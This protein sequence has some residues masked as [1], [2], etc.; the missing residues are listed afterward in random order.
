MNAKKKK[1]R[2]KDFLANDRSI[3]L[4]STRKKL[5]FKCLFLRT[6]MF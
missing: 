1:E 4:L 3:V 6:G 5:S 2:A